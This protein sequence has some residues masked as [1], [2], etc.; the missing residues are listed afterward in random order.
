[1]EAD[2][3][4]KHSL[5]ESL[6][7][8]LNRLSNLDYELLAK[9]RFKETFERLLAVA[10]HVNQKLKNIDPAL[11]TNEQMGALKTA[12][13]S[14]D[15]AALNYI[16]LKD[17]QYISSIKTGIINLLT[18]INEIPSPI[19][20]TDGDAL[21]DFFISI[22]RR[23]GQH[24]HQVE[25]QYAQLITTLTEAEKRTK[26]MLNDIQGQKGRLDSAIAE[27]QKQFS[28]AEDSRR[29]QFAHAE[30]ERSQIFDVQRLDSDVQLRGMI[31]SAT[32]NLSVLQD[33]AKEELRVLVQD[34]TI[35]VDHHLE[36][37]KQY[38]TEA[39]NLVHVIGNTGMV[40]G[41]QEIAN[42]ERVSA[43]WWERIT[44]GTLTA[45]VAF[46]LY[47]FFLASKEGFSWHFLGARAIVLIPLGVMAA[48]AAHKGEQHRLSERNSRR[49]ELE[50]AS[51]NPYLAPLPEIDKNE[52]KKMLA[53]RFFAQ[54]DE[55]GKNNNVVPATGS[56]VDLLRLS[57]ENVK[58]TLDLLTKK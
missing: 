52:V 12:I 11:V 29:E 6:D 13:T 25:Q 43:Q 4:E 15:A 24:V 16:N 49:M 45:L 39:E 20:T 50:L 48:Y 27:Y 18:L 42:K 34:S 28:Q 56:L 17:A 10:H 55:S 1:M 7:M 51:I 30:S 37:L 41:Y 46:G 8:L 53:E 58:S 31:D 19:I 35:N 33:T 54:K 2:Q 14:A 38:K 23:A 21:K 26:E 47:A 9:P 22:R 5:F 44:M 36:L 57:L 3:F 40:G 32:K